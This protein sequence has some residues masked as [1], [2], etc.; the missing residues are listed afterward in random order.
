MS[1]RLYIGH[2]KHDNGKLCP[3]SEQ[4]MRIINNNSDL[5]KMVRVE[6]LNTILAN[7]SPVPQWLDG[8][9]VLVAV[10]TKKIYYGSSAIDT[11]KDIQPPVPVSHRNSQK[12]PGIPLAEANVDPSSLHQ[13]SAS[14][15]ADP[16]AVVEQH[17]EFDWDPG[18][19]SRTETRGKK[20][21]QKELEKMMKER[22]ARTE[23]LAGP[24]PAG[25]DR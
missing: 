23:Q 4:C 7:G 11:L 1:Y 22:A 6:N 10:D 16:D 14:H 8:T 19:K 13:F 2:A 5:E 25:S 18:D 15:E 24:R 3:G 17:D 20:F 21:D 12:P 9:P